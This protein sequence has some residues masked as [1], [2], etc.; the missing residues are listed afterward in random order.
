MKKH[1]CH[2]CGAQI[3][4][5]KAGMVVRVVN[6][7]FHIVTCSACGSEHQF[8]RVCG[9]LQCHSSQRIDLD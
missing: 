3:E 4:D 7:I 1:Y 9:E 2:N 6:T 8:T 5:P